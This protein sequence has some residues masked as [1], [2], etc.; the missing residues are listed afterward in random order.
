MKK[1]KIVI[2]RAEITAF[3]E[4]FLH[5]IPAKTDTGAY[6]S[7]IHASSIKEKRK[8]GVPTLSFDLLEG[9]PNSPYS[10]TIET[11][12]FKKVVVENSFGER[13]ERYAVYLKTKVGPRIFRAEFTLADR[14]RKT[15]P[16]LLGRTLTN[17]RFLVDSAYSNIDRRQLKKLSV[18][19]P[20][21]LEITEPV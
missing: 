8:N 1:H 17:N 11:A 14:A 21:D 9:H 18:N 3:P 2:G 13:Q 4:L 20:E 16:I 12:E 5:D 6:R 10:R 19:L 15:Y 7:A